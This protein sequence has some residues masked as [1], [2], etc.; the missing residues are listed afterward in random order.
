MFTVGGI[1]V[2]DLHQFENMLG[3]LSSKAPV[4]VNRALN[5]TGDMARTQVVRTVAKE[6]S[7]PQKMVRNIVRRDASNEA[8]LTYTIWG[9][10]GDISLKYFKPR[11]TRKGVS[12]FV[13][14]RRELYDSTFLRGGSFA[15]GRVE[16]NM[17]GH[18]FA[19][20]GSSRTP[21]EKL[22]SGVVVP[23]EMV[24]GASVEAFERVVSTHLPR[25]LNHEISR[26]LGL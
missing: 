2:K 23:S 10:G 21:I 25:R 9:A 26:L 19:R 7:L 11:E 24:D 5:R 15:R 12:A 13:R 3:A 17:G 4:A 14:G 6:T 18:V 20:L 8:D 1:D 16:L 22:P